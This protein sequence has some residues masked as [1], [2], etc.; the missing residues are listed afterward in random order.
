MSF[1]VFYISFFCLICFLGLKIFEYKTGK[2]TYISSF[3]KET[4]KIVSH[5][6]LLVKSFLKSLSFK[7][8]AKVFVW[9]WENTVIFVWAL[10][11]RFDSRQPK[12]FVQQNQFDPKGKGRASFFWRN[13]SE[14]KKGLKGN[15]L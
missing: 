14:Y 3:G 12:F 1:I 9:L 6:W 13:V 2:K 4:D 10:K 5:F 15:N 8:T 11:R 7:N